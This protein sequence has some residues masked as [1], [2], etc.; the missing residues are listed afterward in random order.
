MTRRARGRGSEGRGRRRQRHR[1]D[2]HGGGC[3]GH[4]P[5]PRG[6][7]PAGYDG[8]SAGHGNAQSRAGRGNL[9]GSQRGHCEGQERREPRVHPQRLANIMDMD[10]DTQRDGEGG[11]V[12]AG[13][14]NVPGDARQDATITS[15]NG[16]LSV[17]A[18]SKEAHAET[19]T[20]TVD[21]IRRTTDCATAAGNFMIPPEFCIRPKRGQTL[22]IDP[23]ISGDRMTSGSRISPSVQRS[24]NEVPTDRQTAQPMLDDLRLKSK[25][26]VVDGDVPVQDKAGQ[27]VMSRPQGP[28]SDR[29]C[30]NCN[31]TGHTVIN[32][33]D[34][35]ADGTIHGCGCCN[36]SD[37]ITEQCFGFPASAAGQVQ[38]LVVK[39]GNLPPLASPSWYPILLEALQDDPKMRPP[40]RFPWTSEFTK[41]LLQDNTV[42]SYLRQMVAMGGPND[43]YLD[44]STT[45]WDATKKT[46]GEGCLPLEAAMA[47]ESAHPYSR[48]NLRPSRYCRFLLSHREKDFLVDFV[49]KN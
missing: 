38:L 17:G 41:D 47:F 12:D 49:N 25:G 13:K 46:L 29:K 20:Q 26:E 4:Q 24:R 16:G 43:K 2:R 10:M 39:R 8:P 34:S 3:H 42:R 9:E 32:C 5:G 27:S 21:Y 22:A 15:V 23:A 19:H 33:W 6:P 30:G 44:P 36:S 14:G 1:R 18:T 48:T 28:E 35:Q 7:V 45:F 11:A 37:H 40:A 31:Q